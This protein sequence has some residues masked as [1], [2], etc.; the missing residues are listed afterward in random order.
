L[1]ARS[2]NPPEA[3]RSSAKSITGS[4]PSG[5]P[6]NTGT[7]YN[8]HDRRTGDHAIGAIEPVFVQCLRPGKHADL[9]IER[10]RAVVVQRERRGGPVSGQVQPDRRDLQGGCAREAGGREREERDGCPCREAGQ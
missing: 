10:G 9:R 2:D 7:E 3:E 4:F 1:P 5:A 6:T 8:L